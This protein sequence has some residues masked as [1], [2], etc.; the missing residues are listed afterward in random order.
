MKT[1]IVPVVFTITGHI[2]IKAESLAAVKR[3]INKLDEEG[4]ESSLIQDPDYHSDCMVDE[5]EEQKAMLTKV[6]P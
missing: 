5:V 3:K 2:E 1:F 6:P 4:F